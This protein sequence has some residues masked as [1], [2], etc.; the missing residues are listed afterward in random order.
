[1]APGPDGDFFA[2]GEDDVVLH[3][4]ERG[5][6]CDSI[7]LLPAQ[8]ASGDESP[9]AVSDLAS[10][11]DHGDPEVVAAHDFGFAGFDFT[12][13][14]CAVG[15]CLDVEECPLDATSGFSTGTCLTADAPADFR[16]TAIAIDAGRANAGRAYAGGYTFNVRSLAAGTNHCVDLQL[17]GGSSDPIAD[18]AV[19]ASSVWIAV[20]LG[21]TQ[22]DRDF[23]VDSGVAQPE[24]ERFGTGRPSA[25]GLGVLADTDV[26]CL[27]GVASVQEGEEGEEGEDGVWFGTPT[28]FGRIL[29]RASG[30]ELAWVSG[31]SLPGRSV[32]AILAPANDPGILWVATDGGLARLLLAAEP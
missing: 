9:S 6:L 11:F 5:E 24:V 13:R 4:D 26:Q 23:P 20:A 19:S 12:G 25:D 14:P 28:G 3:Y 22:V 10:Q 30:P 32:V 16:A 29:R 27:A 1:M 31:V 15:A 21:I 8:T 2:A 7:R 18:I 17:P